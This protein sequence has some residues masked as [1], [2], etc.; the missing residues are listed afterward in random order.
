[1]RQQKQMREERREVVNEV[2]PERNVQFREN[3]NQVLAARDICTICGDV[4]SDKFIFSEHQ[5]WEVAAPFVGA[6]IPGNGFFMIPD[7][8]N[9]SP[10]KK[11]YQGVVEVLEGDLSANQVEPEFT[12]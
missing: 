10:A 8:R 9:A 4:Y 7:I 1:M 12:Q 2:I 6:A 11:I 3:R 5:P